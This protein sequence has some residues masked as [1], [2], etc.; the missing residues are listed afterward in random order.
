[1][2]IERSPYDRNIAK[3]LNISLEY[4]NIITDRMNELDWYN[5][6]YYSGRY[7]GKPNDVDKKIL[8]DLVEKYKRTEKLK[9]ILDDGIL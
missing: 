5:L 1:M 6:Y 7:I 2:N 9:N 8:D 3:I 4:L